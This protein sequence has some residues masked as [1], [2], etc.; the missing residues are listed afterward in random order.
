M[1][2]CSRLPPSRLRPSTLVTTQRQGASMGA[3]T[4]SRLK[5]TS[6]LLSLSEDGFRDTVVRPLFYRRGFQ[7]GRELCGPQEEG[8]DTIFAEIDKLGFTNF[9]A[10]Q[11]KRGN[12]NLASKA[13]QNLT[14]AIAQ[15]RTAVDTTVTLLK[16][17]RRVK[18][19]KV[20]LIASGTINER[21]RSH[22]LDEIRD[23][24]IQFMDAHELIPLIDENLPELWLGI[25]ADIQP[26]F[27]AIEELVLGKAGRSKLG[28]ASTDDILD[29]I[30]TDE[31][32]VNLQFHKTIMRRKTVRGITKEYP[33]FIEVRLGSLLKDKSQKILILGEAGTG[34]SSC[35]LRLAYETCRDGL[36][37]ANQYQVP[38]LIRAVE[39]QRDKPEDLISY[40]DVRTRAVTNAKRSCFTMEDL[41]RGGVLLLV[42][43]LDEV[44]NNGERSTV[45]QSINRLGELYPQIRIVITSR[46]YRFTTELPELRTYAEYRIS[47]MSWKQAEKIYSRVQ[48][49]KLISSSKINEGL[50]HLEHIQGL[51]LN[52]LLV[53]VFATASSLSQQDVPANITELFKKFTELMLGRWDERKG[54]QHQYQGPL[55]DYVVQHLAFHLHQ[56][57]AK[58]IARADAEELVNSKLSVMGHAAEGERL[59]TEIIER[60]GLF[61]VIGENLEFRH[62]LLQEFFAGRSIQNADFVNSV[63][64][65]EWWS[66]ALVFYFGDNPSRIDLLHNAIREAGS[67]TGAK[68]AQAA[69]AIGLAVQ[70]CY[71]SPV[72]EKVVVWKW[73]ASSLV[74]ARDEA[75]SNAALERRIPLTL[76]AAYY[77]MNRESVALAHLK[78]SSEELVEWSK[79]HSFDSPDLREAAMFWL[80]IGLIE[81]G[82]I[83]RADEIAQH[84]HPRDP[85]LLVALHLSCVLAERIR[86]LD[87]AQKSH[88]QEIHRRISKK[89]AP[90]RQ[91]L[92][93]EWGS[94]LLEYRKGTVTI[95]DEEG[96][97]V[98]DEPAEEEDEIL[99]AIE[100][101]SINRL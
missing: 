2:R 40:L 4:I 20:F 63:V 22:I 34:K 65:D 68:R 73:V 15:L 76:F 47:P 98:L 26:Y 64:T 94:E 97:E 24:N 12:L 90:Y 48:K 84:F 31:N 50:R 18:P 72:A 14:D 95:V 96:D 42:D 69:H 45:L 21:A 6:F 30:A 49:G 43:S 58:F 82:D 10:V 86:P 25:D 44:G 92:L 78:T 27:K 51:E 91:Q 74:E 11:T 29:P 100:K 3:E 8:K 77:L 81:Y 39:I 54:L 56:R 37:L 41:N 85:R 80:L 83:D 1:S 66:R 36:K 75:M 88:A 33:D 93:K 7:D 53:T 32:F 52:P 9:T 38:I 67:A 28:T 5:K 101:Q 35:L 13:S 60:S 19:N 70:A 46:P 87:S 16:D 62:H 79:K 59:L 17:R 23:P 57:K 71:M 61:R 55:K 89:V 99:P